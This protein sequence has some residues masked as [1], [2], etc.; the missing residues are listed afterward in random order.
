[1]ALSVAMAGFFGSSLAFPEF[2]RLSNHAGSPGVSWVTLYFLSSGLAVIFSGRVAQC[3]HLTLALLFFPLNHPSSCVALGFLFFS[4][5]RV[6]D[7]HPLIIPLLYGVSFWSFVLLLV[8]VS[9]L[10]SGA[11]GDVLES[12]PCQRELVPTK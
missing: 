5:Y 12:L 10:V 2:S 11:A 4:V 7:D 6:F 9:A 3:L 1:M 8:F